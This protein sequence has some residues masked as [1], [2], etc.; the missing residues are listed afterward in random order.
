MLTIWFVSFKC[1][2]ARYMWSVLCG[3]VNTVLSFN[4]W[5]P[6]RWLSSRLSIHH[7]M[8][9]WIR[10]LFIWSLDHVIFKRKIRFCTWGA[11]SHARCTLYWDL[12]HWVESLS[13]THLTTRSIASLRSCTADPVGCW[14]FYPSGYQIIEAISGFVFGR[15]P[16]LLED[17]LRWP[18]NCDF[19]CELPYPHSNGAAQ[20]PSSSKQIFNFKDHPRS[21]SLAADRRLD[22]S[23]QET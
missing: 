9:T 10:R 20:C 22:S 15:L 11:S 7:I 19:H 13:E 5:W 8:T 14:C 23:H 17:V 2:Q 16:R 1:A 6:T 12:T 4:D 18:Y 3:L 21:E